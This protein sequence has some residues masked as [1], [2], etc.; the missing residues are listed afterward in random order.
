MVAIKT[1][2]LVLRKFLEKDAPGLLEYFKNPRVACFLDEKIE[3]LDKMLED[4]R[5]RNESPEGTE[6]AVCIRENDNV[7]GNVFSEKEMDDTYS[8][9]WNFNKKCEG[10]GYA[11]EAAKAYLDFLFTNKNER[12][13]YAYVADYN[14]RS[15]KLCERLGM[16]KEGCFLDFISF[17]KD[18]NGVDIYENTIIYAILK[19]EW[20]AKMNF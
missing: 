11:T 1:Q 2:R 13:I 16:R 3:N 10:K 14:I 15:Q 8:V 7:I 6:L 5:R 4:I 17:M 18:E 20:I 12:R 9:G 19:K